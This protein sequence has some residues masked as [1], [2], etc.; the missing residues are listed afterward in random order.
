MALGDFFSSL[1]GSLFSDS[2]RRD[3][4]AHA[5]RKKPGDPPPVAVRFGWLSWIGGLVVCAII[6]PI[7]AYLVWSLFTGRPVENNWFAAPF[8]SALAVV[9]VIVSYDSFVRRI[10]W[11][12]TEVWFRKWNGKRVVPWSDIV[13]LEEKTSPTYLR[14][15]FRD[16]SGFVI[17]ETMRGSHYFLNILE[18][19]LG[20][21]PP[22]SKR[23][24]RRQRGKKD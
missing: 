14:I 13:G 6:L 20:P 15:A 12:D 11:T 16:G 5:N 8:V 21:R 18:R 17:T 1:I 4:I 22:E 24:K 2:I 9:L 19:H 10:E 3:Q 23:R 7:A